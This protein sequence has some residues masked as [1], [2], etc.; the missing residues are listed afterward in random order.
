MHTEH[1][2]FHWKV[3]RIA[4]ISLGVT[5]VTINKQTKDGITYGLK[6]SLIANMP[7][8][9]A[10]LSFVKSFRIH[11]FAMTSKSITYRWLYTCVIM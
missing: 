9:S 4:N 6:N 5:Y 7:T 8:K 11:I 3:W 2:K 10:P 1:G